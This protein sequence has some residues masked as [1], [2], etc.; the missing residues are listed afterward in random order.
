MFIDTWL[1]A[2][3]I[4]FAG[5]FSGMAVLYIIITVVM[6]GKLKKSLKGLQ[7]LGTNINMT[8]LMGREKDRA[9]QLRGM[10]ADINKR[11]GLKK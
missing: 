6:G 3:I 9:S 1:F 2:L 4:F 10:F 7:G 5:F 11:R 8:D